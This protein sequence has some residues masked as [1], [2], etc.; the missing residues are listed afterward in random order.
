MF[1]FGMEFPWDNRHQPHTSLL[2]SLGYHGNHSNVINS[3]V[4]GHIESVFGMEVPWDNKYQ[5][6]TL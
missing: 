2:W 1:I 3:F 4:L 6:L 5:P